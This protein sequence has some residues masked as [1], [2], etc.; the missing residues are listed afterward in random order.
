MNHFDGL[1]SAPHRAF[2]GCPQATGKPEL[3]RRRTL[4]RLRDFGSLK[5]SGSRL[6]EDSSRLVTGNAILA[7][8]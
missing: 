4:D 7:R 2:G 3:I 1:I 6:V 8:N 5:L